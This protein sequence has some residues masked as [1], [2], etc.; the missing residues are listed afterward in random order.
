MKRITLILLILLFGVSSISAQDNDGLKLLL[1]RLKELP[2]SHFPL[3]DLI[4]DSFNPEEQMILF[5]H[6]ER[7]SY[8]L[9]VGE[10]LGGTDIYVA[11]FTTLFGTMPLEG[12]YVIDPIS[13]DF[14]RRIVASDFDENGILYA[15]DFDTNE[16]VTVDISDGAVSVIGT[17]PGPTSYFSGL[18]YDFTTST[19]YALGFN[20]S[21]NRTE[22]HSV[23][24]GTGEFT[25]IGTGANNFLGLWLEIDNDG[26]GY[27]VSPISDALH[28]INLSDGTLDFVG[29]LGIDINGGAHDATINH[30]DNMLY[31]ATNLTS[32]DRGVYS[33]DLNTGAATLLG[34]LNGV[35]LGM[36]ALPATPSLGIVDTNTPSI[37]IYPNPISSGEV[38]LGNDVNNIRKVRLFDV[39]GRNIPVS[40]NKNRINVDF[41][42][43]GIYIIDIETLSGQVGV[44]LIKQ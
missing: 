15:L 4:R 26:N 44:K 32:N 17:Y 27:V 9:R 8:N 23:N 40:L 28:S 34:D 35:P 13:T 39:M 1:N 19:M 24:L 41:L 2:D 42:E 10:N 25:Q 6:L 16:L 12:P 21:Q 14:P 43:S 18:S 11:D 33:I 7:M 38:S 37:S 29:S 30:V 5:K 31:T 22:L 20:S 3:P 36:F